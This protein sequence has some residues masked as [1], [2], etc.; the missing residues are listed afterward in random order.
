MKRIE[1]IREISASTGFSNKKV[2]LLLDTILEVMKES[3]VRGEKI[4]LNGFGYFEVR[5]KKERISTHPKNSDVLIKIDE[6]NN[7][8]FKAS[9]QLKAKVK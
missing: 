6:Q 8:F 7:V 4:I 3:L 5:R 2:D 1:V 9:P